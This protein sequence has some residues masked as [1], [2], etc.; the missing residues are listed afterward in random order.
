MD[1]LDAAL[2]EI[3][4]LRAAIVAHRDDICRDEDWIRAADV[5]LWHALKEK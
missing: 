5:G 4:R 1:A 3:K 2:D